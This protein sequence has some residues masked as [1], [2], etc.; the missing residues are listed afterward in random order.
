[1]MALTTRQRDILQIMLE[2]TKPFSSAELAGLLNLT[3]RQVNYS[4]KGVRVW[5]NQ[6]HQALKTIPGS[7]FAVE[8]QADQA[9]KLSQEIRGTSAVQIIL[10]ASQRQQLLALFL[11]SQAEPNILSQLEQQAQVSRVTI[12]KDLDEIEDWLGNHRIALVRKPH[13]GVQVSGAEQAIQQALAEVLWGEAPFSSERIIQISHADGLVFALDGDARWMSLVAYAKQQLAQLNLRRTIGLVA[14]VEE[15]LGGRFTDDA[16]LHLALAF[17]IS[18]RRV[19]SGHHFDDVPE[20][21]L[22]WL[23]SLPVWPVAGFIARR[24]G[25]DLNATWKPN[26]AVWIAMQLMAAPRNE[27]LPGEIDQ[28]EDFAGLTEQILEYLSQALIIDKLKHDRTLQ[29]GLLTCIV[30]ACYRE[31]FHIWF[32]VS[33]ATTSLPEQDERETTIAGEIAQRVL[34]HTGVNLPRNEIDNLIVLL[35]AAIIR[36][37]TYRFGRIIVVCPSG[38]A[39]AQLLVARLNARFPHLNNLEV[40]SLR[41][42]TTALIAS[43]DLILTTVPLP[44]QFAGSPKMLLVHPLLMPAD[45]EAITQFLS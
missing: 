15:Q 43:A 21:R 24:L 25:R 4:I 1:M 31:R 36:N 12:T 33:L 9:H 10:S 38:M 45:I 30:P 35:R 11:L 14:K 37:R 2:G 29:N 20:Q 40:T 17:A 16:V 22:I 42:L 44:R 5:L 39:T 28:Y 6:H 18:A 41:D 19:Q 8:I 23:Q 32:P 13:F 7:G 26:D 3:P 34:A 27:I